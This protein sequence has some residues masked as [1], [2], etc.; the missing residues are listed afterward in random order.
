MIKNIF[1]TLAAFLFIAQSANAALPENI[2]QA[3][4]EAYKTKNNYII[5]A[6]IASAKK[7]QAQAVYVDSFLLS[8]KQK[9]EA[10]KVKTKLA[11]Q[12]EFK[13]S[14]N[15]EASL[16]LANG[17]TKT[18]NGSLNTTIN[19]KKD[20]WENILKISG[21]NKQENKI[22]TDE[23]YEINNQIKYSINSHDYAFGELEYVSDRFAGYEYRV[24]EAL[25][26][27]R[28]I[29]STD[30]ISLSGEVSAGSRQS[31]LTD[32]T[33]E[34][35]LL[36][37]VALKG[38]WKINGNLSLEQNFSSSIAADSVISESDTTLKSKITDALY[39]KFNY[40]LQHTD[41]VPQN[42]KHIDST[43][44]IGVGYDF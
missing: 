3:I 38:N 29:Y 16:D 31:S 27:G 25:G 24:S 39:L 32:G 2:K 20:K 36:G 21:K 37:K 8:R 11:I 22:R 28:R 43:T 41:D 34:Q 13:L 44:T 42:T 4:E 23:E 30:D 12:N 15:I 1:A 40:N 18:T 17:N 10:A 33:K 19:I 6:V 14:G 5:N 35:S 7:D 9:A 26:Y